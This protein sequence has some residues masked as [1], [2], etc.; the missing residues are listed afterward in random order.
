MCDYINSIAGL[1]MHRLEGHDKSGQPGIHV[2]QVP[3]AGESAHRTSPHTV[4]AAAGSAVPH[5][6]VLLYRLAD[7]FSIDGVFSLLRGDHN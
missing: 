1:C 5:P 3:A 6:F 7:L 4:L 2:R